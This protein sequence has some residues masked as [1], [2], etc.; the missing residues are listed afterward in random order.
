MCI[1]CTVYPPACP[2][3]CRPTLP[4]GATYFRRPRIRRYQWSREFQ[5]SQAQTAQRF[6][7]FSA[8]SRRASSDA[9]YCSVCAIGVLVP[10]A[11]SELAR[12]RLR[13]VAPPARPPH[14]LACSARLALSPSSRAAELITSAASPPGSIPRKRSFTV[15]GSPSELRGPPC[16]IRRQRSLPWKSDRSRE[17][18][19]R[20][21]LRAYTPCHPVARATRSPHPGSP[22][23]GGGGGGAE[24]RRGRRL[25]GCPTIC[26][27]D[28]RSGKIATKCM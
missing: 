25:R 20:S 12:S 23:I 21:Q 22:R 19:P 28:R 2:A 16:S 3:R 26:A 9:H 1:L 15:T 17:H 27:L 7:R 24:T 18:V 4:G 8:V 6:A 13:R 10:P 11:G 14:V 5:R